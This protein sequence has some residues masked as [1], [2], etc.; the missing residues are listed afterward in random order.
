MIF[1][2]ALMF[3][4][5]VALKSLSTSATFS[6]GSKIKSLEDIAEGSRSKNPFCSQ[7]NLISRTKSTSHI[8]EQSQAKHCSFPDKNVDITPIGA[9]N[10]RSFK[11]A[12]ESRDAKSNNLPD[13]LEENRFTPNFLTGQGDVMFSATELDD[14]TTYL[15]DTHPA[16]MQHNFATALDGLEHSYHDYYLQGNYMWENNPWLIVQPESLGSQSSICL[17]GAAETQVPEH[18]NFGEPSLVNN[19][20][21]SSLIETEP[22]AVPEEST[23]DA[24]ASNFRPTHEGEVRESDKEGRSLNEFFETPHLLDFNHDP[25]ISKKFSPSKAKKDVFEK[26]DLQVLEK[27]LSWKL[28]PGEKFIIENKEL[29]QSRPSSSKSPGRQIHKITK[30]TKENAKEKKK[31]NTVSRS[32]SSLKNA[33]NEFKLKLRELSGSSL[34]KGSLNLFLETMDNFADNNPTKNYTNSRKRIKPQDLKIYSQN[35]HAVSFLADSVNPICQ[36]LLY[37]LQKSIK[38]CDDK[39]GKKSDLFFFELINE[40]IKRN[41]D[42]NLYIFPHQ[43]ALFFNVGSSD[44]KVENLV[45]E[46]P[47]SNWNYYSDHIAKKI[48]M[49]VKLIPWK[50]LSTSD[51]KVD[52]FD[53]REI[54]AKH[55]RIKGYNVDYGRLPRMRFEL[56]KLFRAYSTLINKVFCLGEKDLQENFHDRQRA[57]INFFDN[58]ISLLEIDSVDTDVY[59]IENKKLPLD[60]NVKSMFSKHSLNS[61]TGSFQFRICNGDRSKIDIIWKIIGGLKVEISPIPNQPFFFKQTSRVFSGFQ[62]LYTWEGIFHPNTPLFTF[63]YPT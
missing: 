1:R 31:I 37:E 21:L 11:E 16:E 61:L 46:R 38:N 27:Q 60:E 12:F 55:K 44:F 33:M 20:P 63:K 19:Q 54:Y 24:A 41:F 14:F 26:E 58:F 13:C 36:S 52:V 32:R 53:K 10:K 29:L 23:Y 50:E 56:R 7:D 47:P 18:R 35:S 15:T 62:N 8:E 40:Q 48:C 43:V 6:K 49:S 17:N 39:I 45:L 34:F 59:F 28:G 2:K 57:S 22:K 5:L 30:N 51:S 3:L 9:N 42:Q 25:I 4:C